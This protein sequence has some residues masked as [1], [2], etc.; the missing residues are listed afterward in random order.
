[1]PCWGHFQ[2]IER[3]ESFAWRVWLIDKPLQTWWQCALQFSS[4]QVGAISC[5]GPWLIFLDQMVQN[6][7]FW[8]IGRSPGLISMLPE[9]SSSF[10]VFHMWLEMEYEA[11]LWASEIKMDDKCRSW[12]SEGISKWVDPEQYDI[13]LEQCK[14]NMERM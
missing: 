12:I 10:K 4:E 2:M 13:M 14:V 5:C 11:Y 7:G 9:R 1:M 6:T 3:P 8:L